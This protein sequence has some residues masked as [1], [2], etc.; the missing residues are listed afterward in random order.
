M[1]YSS[2]LATRFVQSYALEPFSHSGAVIAL[3]S[4]TST[5]NS[6][7][8]CAIR[9]RSPGLGGVQCQSNSHDQQHLTIVLAH[10]MAF[11]HRARLDDRLPHLIDVA[12][13]RRR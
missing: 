1:D 2:E 10:L 4:L 13:K 11:A 8:V 12:L 5:L 3:R 7:T 9:S 6:S